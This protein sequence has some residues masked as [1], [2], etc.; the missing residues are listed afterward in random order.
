[1][2]TQYS[3]LTGWTPGIDPE[4]WLIIRNY[5]V[6]H[7][8]DSLFWHDPVTCQ[9]TDPVVVGC[10][11]DKAVAVQVAIEE[12]HGAEETPIR[13]LMAQQDVGITDL[14]SHAMQITT[15]RKNHRFCGRCG[16]E[17]APRAG[18][19]AMVCPGCNTPSYP[20]ISPCIIVLVHR[21]D[22][23]LLVQHHRHGGKSSLNTV[24]AG[25]IEPGESAEEAVHREVMEETGLKVRNVRY[26]MSQSWPF[27]HSLM[28]GFHAEYAG[29][30]LILEEKE[31][32][33]GG[34]YSKDSLPAIPPGF[35]ISRQL[36]DKYIIQS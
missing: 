34:W 25:F 17:S 29:G 12:V 24:I 32:C 33:A 20:R 1:M 35:T 19:W 27:P 23:L 10:L 13:E 2:K 9:G 4:L 3:A 18:E 28:L 8:S 5:T 30:E 15:A 36:I 26:C 11:G 16:N 21:G 6:Q 14:L 31:L 7:P 22:E